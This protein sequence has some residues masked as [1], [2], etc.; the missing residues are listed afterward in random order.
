MDAKLSPN[1]GLNISGIGLASSLAAGLGIA[2]LTLDWMANRNPWQGTSLTL[3]LLLCTIAS[4]IAGY[5]VVPLLQ[6]LKT[7]QIIREDGPQAH[8][9]KAGT[10]TMGGIFFIP[11]A[12]VGACVL[13]NFATEVLAVSALTLSYGLI[14]WI[15]DWQI[16]RRKSNKGISPRMKLALQIGFAAAFCLWL[17]F[18]Q[19]ANITSIALPWVSFA[20]PLGFLFWPLAG[21]VLVAESNAT[22][23]TDGID[24]LAGG[25][26]A[27]ALLALGAIVA[28]TSPALMVFCAALSG[29]CLGFLAHNR[30]P[31]RV[32]MG[33]TG[34]LALGGALAAV[35][36]LT[37]SLVALFILSG[38]F[39]V[40]TLSVM[41]QVSY[42]K[43]TK[44]PDGKGKRLLKM[45]PLHHHL[46]LS[47]WSEL[48]V[49]S[50][51]Y[52]IA[53]ILA[54]ICLAIASGGA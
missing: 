53:A 26:V 42:Y 32:F 12:V 49:V 41:A 1:Q 21:F 14:G 7:G 37:N 13:S 19:P 36:L 11:V 46:E 45:A 27:I 25:T 54:A 47:G 38:I 39:F 16:L 23:L 52:V 48:Q 33:D 17:M 24:G 9:K 43:A 18:N 3:P 15:D 40:E 50:S 22:N 4:A 6:A 2:A 29:S 31:A 8:L 30:N 28:P 5:F 20:L 51:F 10:P 35:A 34:S 44:G